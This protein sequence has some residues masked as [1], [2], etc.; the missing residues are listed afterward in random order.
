M[1][2]ARASV[3]SVVPADW[4][5]A[6]RGTGAGGGGGALGTATTSGGAAQGVRRA[7]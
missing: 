5:W 2:M 6:C 7:R 4:T 3:L 1:T